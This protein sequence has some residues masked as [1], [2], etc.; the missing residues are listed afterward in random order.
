MKDGEK[1]EDAPAIGD[2]VTYVTRSERYAGSFFSGRIVALNPDGSLTVRRGRSPIE[3]RIEREQVRV[4]TNRGPCE[5]KAEF[6][7]GCA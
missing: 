5:R 2:V 7:E 1:P 3:E 4:K 6:A